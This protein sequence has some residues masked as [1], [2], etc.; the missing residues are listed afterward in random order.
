MSVESTRKVME[1]YWNSAHGNLEVLAD[2]VVYTIMATGDEARTPEGIQQLL[3]F[4]YQVAFDATTEDEQ[5]LIGDG[6]AMFE[7]YVVGKHTGEFAGIRASG[8]QI[9]VPIC[10]VYD[11]KDDKIH[12]ARIYFEV[13]VLMQQVGAAAPA[14]TTGAG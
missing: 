12:R 13:P 9:R 2:D 8:K 11:L 6:K 10:V 4:F 7:G 5:T 14:E 1:Q 3:N